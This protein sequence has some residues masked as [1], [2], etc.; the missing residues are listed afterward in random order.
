MTHPHFAGAK[1]ALFLDE[2][3]LVYLRDDKPGIPHPNQWDL[4]GGGREGPESPL[5]CALRELQEEFAIALAPARIVW[6]QAYPGLAAEN[7]PTYFFAAHLTAEDIDA[8][9]FGDEG[10]H[11]A[12]MPVTAFL[13][14]PEGVSHLQDRVRD[15]LLRYSAM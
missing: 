15:F 5:Q 14:H 13:A 6:T 4:P 2:A 8:I 7:A 9:R 1:I 3:I 12:L 11:W 10:Q